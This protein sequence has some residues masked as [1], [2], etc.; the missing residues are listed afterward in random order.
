[1]TAA[2]GAPSAASPN[3]ERTARISAVAAT[4]C[5]IH[6]AATPMLAAAIPFLAVAESVEWWALAVTVLLG[7]G[8][9]LMG[10]E[11]RRLPVLGVLGLGAAVWSASLLGFFEPMPETVTSPA[12]S[13]IFAAGMMWSARICRAGDCERC[14][15]G[16][17]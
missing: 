14:E 17:S 4:L 7:G 13:L 15:E 3:L 1:V 9:T 5:A 12:G 8:V 16:E 2:P 10:P 11:R 6:C